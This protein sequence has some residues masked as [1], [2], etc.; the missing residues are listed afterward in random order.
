MLCIND[1]YLFRRVVIVRYDMVYYRYVFEILFLGCFYCC[2]I[3]L[4][5]YV[6]AYVYVYV[7]GVGKN[8]LCFIEVY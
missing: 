7:H 5:L 2:H 6:D 1:S 4:D 8:Y 3:C